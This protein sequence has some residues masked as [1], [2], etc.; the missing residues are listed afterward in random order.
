M[1]ESKLSVHL[2]ITV[3]ELVGCLLGIVPGLIGAWMP[4]HKITVEEL[5]DLLAEF[6]R[7][8]AEKADPEAQ[9]LLEWLAEALDVDG[10]G[11]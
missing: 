9:P 2:G 6:I 3:P 5:R 4:D 8:L 11:E 7:D 1:S 10:G